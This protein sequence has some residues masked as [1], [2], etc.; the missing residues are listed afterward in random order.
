MTDVF[1]VIVMSATR[2]FAFG[3]GDGGIDIS[4]NLLGR[5]LRGM[6]VSAVSSSP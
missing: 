5:S 1:M 3:G 4:F 2:A 6:G